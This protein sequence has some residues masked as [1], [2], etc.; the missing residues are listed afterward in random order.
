MDRLILRRFP[1]RD[2]DRLAA[3]ATR[4]DHAAFVVMA[5]LVADFVAEVHIYSPDMIPKAVQRGMHDGFHMVRKL[6]AALNVAVLTSISINR[7]LCF[8]ALDAFRSFDATTDRADPE[9]QRRDDELASHREKLTL[10]LAIL[11]EQKA[12]K[13]WRRW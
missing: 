10:E 5:D 2:D 13:I 12:A 3:I 7:L 6:F 11:S 8:I 1:M 9:T 4:F